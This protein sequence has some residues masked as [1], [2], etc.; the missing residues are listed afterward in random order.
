[1]TVTKKHAERA[2]LLLFA[3]LG[4]ALNGWGQTVTKSGIIYTATSENT[5]SVTGVSNRLVGA[6][7]IESQIGISGKSRQVTAISFQAFADQK[8]LRKLTLPAQL[9]SIGMEAFIGCI[10]LQELEGLA[11]VSHVGSYA[12]AG[13]ALTEIDMSGWE[14]KSLGSGIFSG[15][16]MLKQ[17]QLPTT[18]KVLPARTFSKCSALGQTNLS[19]IVALTEIGEGAFAGCSSLL[20]LTLPESVSTL[21]PFAFDGMSSLSALELPESLVRIGDYA[22]RGCSSLSELVLPDR[23]TDLGLSPFYGCRA[24]KQVTL[25][26]RLKSISEN[27]VFD[28]CPALENIEIPL[29][30]TLYSSLDGVLYNRTKSQVIAW[31]AGLSRRVHPVV[32]SSSSPLAKGALMDCELDEQL[33]LPARM[34]TL[35]YDALTRTS[36]MKGLA[37][38]QG[39]VLSKVD[40]RAVSNSKDLEVIDLPATLRQIGEAAFLGCTAVGDVIVKGSTPSTA[41]ISTFD[42]VTYSGACLHVREGAKTAFSDHS[43]WGCFSSI[44][45]DALTTDVLPISKETGESPVYDLSGRRINHVSATTVRPLPKGIYIIEGRKVVK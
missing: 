16:T 26:R 37:V 13:T 18:L 10:T 1:M 44:V 6:K 41:H 42:E 9:D 11:S 14:A 3:V 35:P 2:C 24:L 29:Q 32:P 38:E 30:N 33:W 34:S 28:N 20:A 36:G 27:F 4:L 19:E 17:A 45:D 12:F 7:T 43:V 31:P 23:L 40:A 25:S 5:A 15:C 21:Q 39:S 8:Y 22:F